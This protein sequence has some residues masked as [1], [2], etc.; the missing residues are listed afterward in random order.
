MAGCAAIVLIGTEHQHP[1]ECTA[2]QDSTPVAERTTAEQSK[3]YATVL[4]EI[5]HNR[6]EGNPL[7]DKVILI[8]IA[9][10]LDP[11]PIALRVQIAN[12]IDNRIEAITS[13]EDAEILATDIL[14]LIG[15]NLMK[16]DDPI[17]PDFTEDQANA[18]LRGLADA[19][20]RWLMRMDGSL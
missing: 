14:H 12:L 3:H 4:R 6:G 9:N 18:Y 8:D 19:Q 13:G 15:E 17:V 20:T 7:S 5:A 16:M 2:F 11:P 10:Y 1:C